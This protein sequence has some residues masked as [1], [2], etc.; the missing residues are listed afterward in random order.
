MMN[1]SLL[2]PSSST[3]PAAE[4][5]GWLCPQQNGARKH[6]RAAAK[7][8]FENFDEKTD[9]GIIVNVSPFKTAVEFVFPAAQHASAHA[10]RVP[11][12]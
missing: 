6:T 5:C 8:A 11:R 9:A 7:K 1:R 3:L 12:A 4:F 10:I 2:V